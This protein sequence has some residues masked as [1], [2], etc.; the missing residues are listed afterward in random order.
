MYKVKKTVNTPNGCINVQGQQ[1]WGS[2]SIDQEVFVQNYAF[3]ANRVIFVEDHL[4]IDGQIDGARLTISAGLLPENPSKLKDIMVNKDLLYTNYDG[5]DVIGLIAQGDFTVGWV[6]E[7]DLRIDAAIVSQNR[8]IGRNYY[9][10]PEGNQPRCS[11]Y[12]TR[13]VITTYGILATFDEYGFSYTDGTGYQQR[14]I[15]YD[16]NLLFS[17]PPS[18]PTGSQ[19][20]QISWEEL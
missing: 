11:P 7:D 1:D 3:P 15:I 9:R 8:R 17:P 4:W 2:W 16:P 10:G 20:E 19:Y 5:T 13:A 14:N 18:F 6:S 12:H